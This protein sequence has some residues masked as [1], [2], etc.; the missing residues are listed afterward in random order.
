[1]PC[2]Q[3]SRIIARTVE[4]AIRDIYEVIEMSVATRV[5]HG[6]PIPGDL[7]EISPDAEGTIRVDDAVALP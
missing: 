2:L 7:H 5:R 4:D 6:E 1:V 3:G